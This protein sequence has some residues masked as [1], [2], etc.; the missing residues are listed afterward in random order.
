A[1]TYA[2]V[3][4]VVQRGKLQ[5]TLESLETSADRVQFVEY[6]EHVPGTANLLRFKVIKTATTFNVGI[7][8]RALKSHSYIY[9]LD[10]LD[11]CH[12]VNTPIANQV[13]RKFYRNLVVNNS[14][15]HCPIRTG[16][17]Y[18]RNL[19]TASLMPSFHPAGHFQ[20]TVNVSSPFSSASY[21][22]RMVWTYRISFLK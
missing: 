19:L 13:F 21:I 22:M 9:R 10:K 14:F 7:Y 18:L 17:Y 4:Q 12:F 2:S 8:L 20:L 11:G 16:T 15:F 1:S 6:F 5:L 3:W